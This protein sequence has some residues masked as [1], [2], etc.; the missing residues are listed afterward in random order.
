MKNQSF[1]ILLLSFLIFH[2]DLKSQDPCNCSGEGS[3]AASYA[4]GIDGPNGQVCAYC[5]QLANLLC[6]CACESYSEYDKSK[7]KQSI[8]QVKNAMLQF[9]VSC[10]SD[11][12]SRTCTGGTSNN[13]DAL[14]EEPSAGYDIEFPN[15]NT[16]NSN[17]TGKSEVN[18]LLDQYES[19]INSYLGLLQKIISGEVENLEESTSIYT[20]L[21][22][23]IELFDSIDFLTAEQLDRLS[24]LSERFAAEA[25]KLSEQSIK[26]M[27]NTGDKEMHDFD[28]Q[29]FNNISLPS[30]ST[31]TAPSSQP[32]SNNNSNNNSNLAP[33][34]NLNTG[35][36]LTNPK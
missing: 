18:M 22:E 27:E 35:G 32:P 25:L 21:M 36:G 26:G 6:L 1:Y 29:Q 31:I 10:C 28:Y 30:G 4:S 20:L 9:S 23:V 12:V 5:A 17:S 8:M 16:N 15:N 11:L 34:K 3:Q 14:P 2:N 13:L 33:G 24:K 7:L 19:L